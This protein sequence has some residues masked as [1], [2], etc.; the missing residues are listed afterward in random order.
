VAA[1]PA[2]FLPLLVRRATTRAA[3][4]IQAGSAVT[5]EPETLRTGGATVATHRHG[6]YGTPM[7]GSRCS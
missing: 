4:H 3:R 2:K 1:L 5:A 7:T 6:R